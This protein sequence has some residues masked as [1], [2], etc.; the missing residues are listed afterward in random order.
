MPKKML[1]GW[2]VG[3]AIS[4][5]TAF[6]L[7]NLW[8]WFG[9]PA[10]HLSQISFWVMYGLVLIVGIFAE[11]KQA[12]R[13]QFKVLATMIDFC[14]PSEK[15]EEADD[16]IKHFTREAKLD[17]VLSVGVRLASNSFALVIGWVVHVFLA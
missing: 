9:V 15:R 4:L 17:D 12:E 16:Q 1:L 11:G 8:N 6:V 5:Y 13:R 3:S 2:A 7:Q 10:F 14:V